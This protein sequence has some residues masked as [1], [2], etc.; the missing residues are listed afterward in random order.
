MTRSSVK[1]D[2]FVLCD[3]VRQELNGKMLLIG[4]YATD[5]GVAQFPATFAF[6]IHAQGEVLKD[7]TFSN[8]FIIRDEDGGILFRQIDDDTEI[9]FKIGRFC[10]QYPATFTVHKKSVLNFFAV[11]DDEEHLIGTRR[12]SNSEDAKY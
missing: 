10:V 7:G 3:D 6:N 8:K 9:N 12:V 5:I 2:T 1:Y 11:F 4:V